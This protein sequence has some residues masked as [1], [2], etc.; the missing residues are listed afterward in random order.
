VEARVSEVMT[1][2][3]EDGGSGVVAPPDEAELIALL[4]N[5]TVVVCGPGLGQGVGP[6]ALVEALLRVVDVPLVLDADALNAIAGTRLLAGAA[7]PSC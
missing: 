1:A 3:I 2:G 6:R 5:R 7:P 4:R